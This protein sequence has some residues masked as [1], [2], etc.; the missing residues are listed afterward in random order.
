M[1]GK[2]LLRQHHLQWPP[3]R[4]FGWQM[5]PLSSAHTTFVVRQNGLLELTIAHDLVR[6]VTPAM[7]CWWFLHIDEVMTYQ[8]HSYPRY[9]VWHPADHILYQDVTRGSDGSAGVGSSRRIVEAFGRNAA[10][11]VDSVEEVCKLDETGIV[12]RKRIGGIEVF[13]LE[14]HFGARPLGT[15]YSS[16][17]IVGTSTPIASTI[18][19][20]L[21]RPRLFS[22]EMGHAWLQHNI[23][24]V[25]NFEHFLPDL[26]A[27]CVEQAPQNTIQRS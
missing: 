10:Y 17:M 8:G 9:L 26:Y 21:V 4:T 14:H 18:F 24:E 13:S 15:R 23:E 2:H 20:S 22:N 19:N 12:L 6:G 11:V 3:I 25:G 5:K 7:L 27:Q 1:S 16:R